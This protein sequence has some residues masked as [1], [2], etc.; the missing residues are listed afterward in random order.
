AAE[1]QR[2]REL[3]LGVVD[4][5]LR[6]PDSEK[7]RL[8][9]GDT[10]AALAD[11]ATYLN[12]DT[13]L[14]WMKKAYVQVP[15]GSRIH[16]PELLAVGNHG[17]FFLP[18]NT[19]GRLE[20]MVDYFFEYTKYADKVK[21]GCGHGYE[22]LF[23]GEAAYNRA[24]MDNAATMFNSAML[25][26]QHTGQHDIICNALWGLGRIE[27]YYGNHKN[28]LALL[29]EII[30][31]VDEGRFV[32][33]YELRDCA[34]AHFYMCLDDLDKVPPWL[35]ETTSG[36][37]PTPINIARKLLMSA[38]YLHQKGEGARAYAVLLQLESLLENRGRW[39]EKLSLYI[40]KAQHLMGAGDMA[41]FAQA[42]KT[43]YDMVYANDLKLCLAESGR[44]MMAMLDC[45]KRLEADGYD[46]AWLELVYQDASS[47][48][49]RL[50]MMREAY[51]GRDHSY[52]SGVA[53]TKREDETLR[54]LAQG[55]TQKEV[56]R[57]MG[58]SENAVKKHISK[59]YFKL[60][61]VN[62]ADA[63]H[64]ATVNG[65]VDVLK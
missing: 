11:I 12:E 54:Y 3:F 29:G 14:E 47:F 56:G 55:L 6:Q 27:L 38:C 48:A 34:I 62:R 43:A 65:L 8:L 17:A 32:G 26:A 22:Y 30:K 35:G 4:R 51:K 50:H 1:V 25:K 58:I 5:L 23:A 28:A 63:I 18:D 42:F 39:P 41:G 21:R 36:P 44:D 45:L 49:K 33:V 52:R 9:L 16:S 61:A 10:Y 20:R 60:G 15:H 13:G 24:E 59:I 2:A 19:P 31:Y 53:L 46:W 57:L 40:F 37:E 64:I 7:K